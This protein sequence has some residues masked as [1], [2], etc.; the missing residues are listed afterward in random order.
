MLISHDILL[1]TPALCSINKT[2][3]EI[4]LLDGFQKVFVQ[5]ESLSNEE[6]ALGFHKDPMLLNI[7][8]NDLLVN[9]KSLLLKFEDDT[10]MIDF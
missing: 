9:V 3:F 6:F 8:T 1:E 10:K 2:H 5:G 7:L 4:W